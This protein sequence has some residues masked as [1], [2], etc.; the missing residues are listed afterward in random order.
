MFLLLSNNQV[1][2]KLVFNFLVL[3]NNKN[4]EVNLLGLLFSVHINRQPLIVFVT[5]KCRFLF[6]F[7][8]KNII[9]YSIYVYD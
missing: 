8:L 6:A 7:F 5:G 2:D 9:L 4:C 3:K 1:R